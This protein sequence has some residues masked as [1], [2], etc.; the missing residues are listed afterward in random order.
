MWCVLLYFSCLYHFLSR[1]FYIKIK[2]IIRLLVEDII[3]ISYHCLGGCNVLNY[4]RIQK[5]TLTRLF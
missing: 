2:F 1:N 4:C 5:K 3:Y